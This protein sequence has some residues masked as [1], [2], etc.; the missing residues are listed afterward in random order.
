MNHSKTKSLI[1][2]LRDN[3]Y[4]YFGENKPGFSFII[5]I[6]LYIFI[7]FPSMRSCCVYCK[8]FLDNIIRNVFSSHIPICH[9]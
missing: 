7:I 8:L 1:P 4:Y 5:Y 6:H 2:I 9:F 3:C